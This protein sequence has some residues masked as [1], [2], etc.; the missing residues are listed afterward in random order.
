MDAALINV[1]IQNLEAMKK[2]GPSGANDI[3]TGPRLKGGQHQ[4]YYGAPGTGK[5]Y[6]VEKQAS[7]GTV[8]RTVFHPDMQNSD[9]FGTLKPVTSDSGKI[10]YAFSPG[11]FSKAL[12]HAYAL[13]LI[14]I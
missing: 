13:S 7:S 5:S 11:P 2:S 9:F 1:A 4:I 14:H 12:A 3:K 6:S 10:N 8:F